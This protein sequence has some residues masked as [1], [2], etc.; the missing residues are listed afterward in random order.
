MVITH[1]KQLLLVSNETDEYY[2]G[3]NSTTFTVYKHAAV[4]SNVTVPTVNTTVGQSVTI[5]VTMGNVTSGKVIIEVG[6]HDYTVDIDDNGIAVLVVDLPVGSY[7]A[8]AY[9]LE[10]DKYNATD[11]LNNTKFNVTDKQ[12]ATIIINAAEFVEIEHNLIFNITNSTPVVVTINDVVYPI[13]A[14][15]NYTFE[16][17]AAGDLMR[18]MSITLDSTAQHSQSTNTIQL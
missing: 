1:L 15:G 12:N 16:A 7:T 2:V 6:G 4:I 13:G 10:S 18:L 8:H 5:T 17:T 3:F 14:D 9:Y 11:K